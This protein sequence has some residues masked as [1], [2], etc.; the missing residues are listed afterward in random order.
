[1][2]LEE[3]IDHSHDEVNEMLSAT[4]S[5][6]A[7]E[8]YTD[9]KILLI[10]RVQFESGRLGFKSEF[11]L[12]KDKDAFYY[13]RGSRTFS[14]LS[15]SYIELVRLLDEYYKNN[16]KI[17]T[18]YSGQVE[19]LETDLFNR[20]LGSL[21]MDMWFDL[22]KDL[23]KLEN[24]YYRNGIV[25]HEFLKVMDTYFGKHKDEFKDIEDSIQFQ[26]SNISTLKSRLDGVHHYYDSIK[27]DRLNKT[28]LMLTII[29]GVFLPL[30]LIVGFFGMNTSGLFFANDPSGTENVLLILVVVLL[31][32][33]LGIQ[34]LHLIDRFVLRF[35]LGRYNFYKNISN[36][37]EELSERFRVK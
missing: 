36:R 8:D 21:F 26:S 37:V 25:Y 28:L 10:R 3:L 13:D 16:Q 11:F 32:C 9:F 20:N 14:K 34:I 5:F 2:K 35:I 17:I 6:S 19:K 18:A 4:E 12:L 27:S 23:S 22:K 31:V 1:M 29:S 33:A 24:Y 30:N 15:K 7:F